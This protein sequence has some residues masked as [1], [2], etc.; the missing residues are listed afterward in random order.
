V[1]IFSPHGDGFHKACALPSVWINNFAYTTT[2]VPY[3]YIGPSL[4]SLIIAAWRLGRYD[5]DGF[6]LKTELRIFFWLGFLLLIFQ[7]YEEIVQPP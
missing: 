3:L 2:I 7:V 4:L 1:S 5:S 6:K